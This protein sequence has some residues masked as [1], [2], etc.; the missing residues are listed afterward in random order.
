[1][2]ITLLCVTL[3]VIFTCTGIG[4]AHVADGQAASGSNRSAN[5][6]PDVTGLRHIIN[7][8]WTCIEMPG[9]EVD[10]VLH[11]MTSEEEPTAKVTYNDATGLYEIVYR[12]DDNRRLDFYGK[13]MCT[14]TEEDFR[15]NDAQLAKQAPSDLDS[16]H[17]KKAVADLNRYITGEK[18]K[19]SLQPY[20]CGE[21]SPGDI[22][23]ANGKDLGP[24]L[25]VDVADPKN[26]S[27]VQSLLP[28]SIDGY[29]VEAANTTNAPDTLLPF[30]DGPCPSGGVPCE[31]KCEFPCDNRC[32]RWCPSFCKSED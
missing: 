31:D 26:T 29:R 15:Y 17:M 28:R 24:G 21:A 14:L 10:E 18:G 27:L 5:D 20:I 25:I 30:S 16:A 13:S 11:R 7:P 9:N 23:D 12:P 22:G 32:F 3:L 8:G 19:K 2:K 4:A 6:Q 1:M